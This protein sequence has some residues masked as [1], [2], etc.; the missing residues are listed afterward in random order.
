[1]RT[2]VHISDLHFGRVDASLLAPLA[3]AIE[4]ARPDVLA[5]SGDLT[6]RARTEQFKQAAAFLQQLPQP[7]IVVPGNHDVPLYDVLRRFLSP[8]ARFRRYI[9]DEE[10]PYFEDEEIAVIGVNTARS[11]T[12]KGGRINR[13]Q[14][15]EVE[16]RFHGLA[17]PVTRIVVTHHPFDIPDWGAESD[18]VG[19]ATMAMTAF[20]GCEVD[21]FLSGHLHRPHAGT[22]AQRYRID[23]F[24]ALIIQAGTATSTRRRGEDNAF[25]V[26]RIGSKSLT[27]S[28]CS[29]QPEQSRF[30]V[31]EER[32]YAYVSGRGW[33]PID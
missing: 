7:Q 17:E 31:V 5:I 11:L 10:F 21:L 18:V 33:A 12:F 15:D 8:L 13:K 2:V 27:L 26:I 25:N 32:T 24:A 20:S 4:E 22:T 28:T 29:W 1:M 16:R 9:S 14:V 30:A 19:R 3:Q 6:Q 23:G